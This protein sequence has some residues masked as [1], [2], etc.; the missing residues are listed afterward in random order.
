MK[1]SRTRDRAPGTNGKAA[2]FELR[3]SLPSQVAA[4][5]PFVVRLMR[6][7]ARFRKEDGSRSDIEL[8]V[9]EALANA[10]IH[11]NHEHADKRVYVRC[12][13]GQDGE[14][15]ITIRDQGQGFDQLGVPDPEAPENRL[16]T[17]GRG[18]FL[19]RK[20]M[21]EVSFDEGGM[22]VHMRKG[23]TNLTARN[24]RK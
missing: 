1:R 21:D 12:R 7:I 13:C 22:A 24:T 19:M 5:S 8:A 10:M 4:I 15:S 3:Q 23:P 6:F 16:S 18:I 14:V 11:G 17:H 2:L 20:L 9:R